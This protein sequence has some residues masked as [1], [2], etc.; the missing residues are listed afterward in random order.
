MSK[1]WIIYKHT[2]TLNNKVYIGQTCEYR[3]S[4]RWGSGTAYF[5]KGKLTPFAKAIIKYGWI[6]FR[7]EILE[8]NIESQILANEREKYWIHYYQSDKKEFG[9]NSTEGGTGT[10]N[11][12]E[13]N[14]KNKRAVYK[15]KPENMQIVEEY[16]SLLAASSDVGAEICPSKM[17]Y[18]RGFYWC[19]KEEWTPLWVPPYPKRISY[20]QAVFDNGKYYFKNFW[21]TMNSIV[22]DL[23]MDNRTIKDK[24]NKEVA[25]QGN[26]WFT[27]KRWLELV[28]K[29]D[30]F[31]ERKN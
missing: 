5:G 15:I 19:Y 18:A 9:Y 17:S 13:P 4:Q 10:H 7:H 8:K 6:N 28:Q 20:I 25:F 29:G 3:P 2:N 24:V 12:N 1:K 23:H 31:Y 27:L 30:A 26:Y 22:K 14:W 21:Y 16:E 11:I